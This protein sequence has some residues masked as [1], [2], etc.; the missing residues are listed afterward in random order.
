MVLSL[1][2]KN[3]DYN[4]LEVNRLVEIDLHHSHFTISFLL[5]VV[6]EIVGVKHFP[7][8]KSD[9]AAVWARCWCC[10]QNCDE[11]NQVRLISFNAFASV[12]GLLWREIGYLCSSFALPYFFEAVV[13]CWSLSLYSHFFINCPDPV[14]L[15]SSF[16]WNSYKINQTQDKIGVFVSIVSTKIPF[17]GTGKE[18]IGDDISEIASAVKVGVPPYLFY[19]RKGSIL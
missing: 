2:Q 13:V 8:C 16:S 14:F 12:V 18:Y 15:L 11:E 7:V 5:N 3:G 9:S 6:I 17:K 4:F 19:S 1:Y 10:H